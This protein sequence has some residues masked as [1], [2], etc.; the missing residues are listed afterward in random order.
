[1]AEASFT[2]H[3]ATSVLA[4]ERLSL[5]VLLKINLL[6]QL[7]Q[8]DIFCIQSDLWHLNMTEPKSFFAIFFPHNFHNLSKSELPILSLP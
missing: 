2:E 4:T 7:L 1:L 8:I 3:H 5:G 6:Y